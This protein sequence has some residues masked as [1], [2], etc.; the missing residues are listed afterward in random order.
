MANEEIPVAY[1]H[2]ET[3]PLA[4]ISTERSPA[5]I[6]STSPSTTAV[7]PNPGPNTSISV[8]RKQYGPHF[9]KG[10]GDSDTLGQVLARAGVASLAEYLE[11][12]TKE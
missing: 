9:A 6:Q 12:S 7:D 3:S 11:Q 1:P 4:P 10:Y 8:L 2:S 5:N